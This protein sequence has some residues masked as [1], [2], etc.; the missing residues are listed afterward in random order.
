MSASLN[1]CLN[2]SAALSRH[3]AS[4]S[5]ALIYS[6][7]Y[8]YLYYRGYTRFDE[9]QISILLII[10]WLGNFTFSIILALKLNRFFQDTS[11]S[12]MQLL[13]S[14]AFAIIGVYYLN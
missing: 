2:L 12:M 14:T 1:T 13:W 7:I 3:I 9:H 4:L 6:I 8:F 5:A 10:F 11:M